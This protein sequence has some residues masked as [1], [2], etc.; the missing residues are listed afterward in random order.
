MKGSNEDIV[1]AA[2][3]QMKD[4]LLRISKKEM[5]RHFVK[6][7]MKQDTHMTMPPREYFPSLTVRDLE[8]SLKLL[9][10]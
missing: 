8:A 2:L 10:T 9:P 7:C 4:Q 5:R 1:T 3:G 6:L